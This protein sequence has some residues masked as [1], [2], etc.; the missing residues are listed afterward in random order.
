MANWFPT[1]YP[2]I[3]SQR[4]E[5][6]HDKGWTVTLISLSD[7]A[8]DVRIQV[9]PSGLLFRRTREK[10]RKY[11][12][13]S[14][15]L[16]HELSWVQA[17]ESDVPILHTKQWNWKWME[18]SLYLSMVWK[19]QRHLESSRIGPKLTEIPASKLRAVVLRRWLQV[20][21]IRILCFQSFSTAQ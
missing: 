9:S 10:S 6:P 1:C 19:V 12:Q 15:R 2:E 18:H 17:S 7:T 3:L 21:R 14:S 4:T 13:R 5:E 20:A 16:Q 11:S 8:T